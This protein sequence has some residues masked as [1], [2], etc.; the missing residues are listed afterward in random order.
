[1]MIK[2]WRQNWNSGEFSFYWS[3][4]ADFAKSKDKDGI[5]PWAEMRES[6]TVAMQNTPKTGQAV[7]TDLGEDF[8]IHPRHV[9]LKLLSVLFVGL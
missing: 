1:M 2:T 5:S 9:N 4:L 3:Q 7:I 6:M 8:D